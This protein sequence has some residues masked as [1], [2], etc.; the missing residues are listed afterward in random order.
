MSITA[1]SMYT[2]S[3]C[4]TDSFTLPVDTTQAAVELAELARSKNIPI[5]LDCEKDRPHFRD[6]LPLADYL[7]C[8]SGFAQ[9]YMQCDSRLEGM[10]ALLRMGTAKLV[11][12][13]LGAEGSVLMYKDPPWPGFNDAAAVDSSMSSSSDSSSVS[14]STAADSTPLTFKHSKYSSSSSSASSSASS[15]SSSSTSSTAYST[16]HCSAWSV[17][18]SEIVD[19]TGAY[20]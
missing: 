1:G 18:R 5:V 9:S 7:V 11:V 2:N 15:S 16:V 12:S 13:T 20:Y 3:Y 4:Y 19:T 17:Q 6:L 10:A 14:S 8:N